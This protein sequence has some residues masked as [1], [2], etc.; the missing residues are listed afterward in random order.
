M[1]VSICR[2]A[3]CVRQRSLFRVRF[4]CS[5]LLLLFT[6]LF[7][8]HLPSLFQTV[9]VFQRKCV[10]RIID[11]H[12][13]GSWKLRNNSGIKGAQLRNLRHFHSIQL[14][15]MA[16][17]RIQCIEML[18]FSRGK[19]TKRFKMKCAR[20]RRSKRPTMTGYTNQ[21]E[22]K[23]RKRTCKRI[24]PIRRWFRTFGLI[25]S[26]Q[27]LLKFDWCDRVVLAIWCN[28]FCIFN[29]LNQ[30]HSNGSKH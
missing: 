28:S 26:V 9:R 20:D 23:R 25:V 11:T 1:F 27:Q 12:K 17:G 7:P 16:V 6:I 21:N 24:G 5:L 19:W 3:L 30:H 29:P 22:I 10:G 8:L 15:F 2:L 4:G 14:Q 18:N 13:I